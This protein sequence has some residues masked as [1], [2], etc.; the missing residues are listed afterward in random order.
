MKGERDPEQMFCPNPCGEIGLRM[1]ENCNLG[2]INLRMFA[3]RPPREVVEAFRLMTRF[4]IRAT[5]SDIPN[6]RQR[7]VVDQNRRIGVGFF[8][9]HGW[10]ALQGIKYSEAAGNEEVINKLKKWYEVVSSEAIKYADELGIP[11]P[12]KN[13]CLAPTGTITCLSGDESS[14]QC[15]FAPWLKRRVRVSNMDK[16]RIAEAK[17][18]GV[19]TY[20]DPDA[21]QTTIL[22]FWA[23]SPLVQHV[24]NAGFDPA[25]I[26]EGQDEI[27]PEVC[28]RMQAMLQSA[29][30]DNAISYT[31]NLPKDKV[32]HQGDLKALLIPFLSQL[33]GTTMFPE[34]SRENMPLER[35]T[36][37]EWDAYTGPKEISQVEDPCKGACPI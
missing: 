9:F 22:E 19:P 37:E 20:P 3:S 27:A 35:V 26:L 7:A 5:H 25:D 12:I 23:E 10:L 13:T 33:K 21:D 14:A 6:P 1:W 16:D 2:H 31:I 30:A 32:Q 29:W 8:G 24:R 17:L 34:G 18:K 4:L 11:R 36:K 15:M 28:L